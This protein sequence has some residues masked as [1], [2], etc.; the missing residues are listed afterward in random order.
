MTLHYDNGPDKLTAI[1][2]SLQLEALRRGRRE[3]W[4]PGEEGL[5]AL[6]YSKKKSAFISVGEVTL[7]QLENWK[8]GDAMENY[9]KF[10]LDKG[11]D[12]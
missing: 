12:I 10:L 6:M 11:V 8:G 2:E 4:M 7:E 3:E 9:N 1:I 5:I